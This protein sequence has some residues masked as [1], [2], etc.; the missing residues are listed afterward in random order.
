MTHLRVTV[1]H[2]HR[3][4][5]PTRRADWGLNGRLRLLEARPRSEGICRRHS[6]LCRRRLFMV[7]L[8]S[9]GFWCSRCLRVSHP[10]MRMNLSLTGLK[11]FMWR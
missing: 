11:A 2:G 8:L 3:K 10:D 9:M 4:D 7:L 5:V 1:G 6:I